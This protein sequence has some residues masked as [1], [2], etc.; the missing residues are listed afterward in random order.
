MV[1]V[2]LADGSRQCL[3]GWTIDKVT[4]AL[5]FVDL[6]QAAKELKSI[7]PENREL[8]NLQCPPEIGG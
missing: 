3:E 7:E 1:T 6:T 2:N 4:D 5:P 8:Q